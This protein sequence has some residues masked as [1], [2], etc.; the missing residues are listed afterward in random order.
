MLLSYTLLAAN[1]EQRMGAQLLRVAKEG[2]QVSKYPAV[3]FF[4]LIPLKIVTT[5]CDLTM[6]DEFFNEAI[7]GLFSAYQITYFGLVG[8]ILG[9]VY[10]IACVE[11][12]K[13]EGPIKSNKT[14]TGLID[15]L[16][17]TPI[18]YVSALMPVLL[19]LNCWS[20]NYL[21]AF[22]GTLILALIWLSLNVFRDIFKNPQF[23]KLVRKSD[24]WPNRMN[25]YAML[26][27]AWFGLGWLIVSQAYEVSQKAGG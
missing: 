13:K 11:A 4:L 19:F 18:A 7:L 27:T 5:Y 25:G 8:Y 9:L 15:F 2:H 16:F 20:D 26:L 12:S 3:F 22:S 23:F 1:N 6:L 10:F 21:Y 14:V 17:N 24:F